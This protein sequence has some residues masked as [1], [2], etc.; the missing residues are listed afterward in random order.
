M[1]SNSPSLGRSILVVVMVSLGAAML[2]TGTH[3][4]SKD[5]I[6]FNERQRLLENLNSVLGDRLR[7]EDFT[8]TQLRVSNAELLGTQEPVD[9][10]VMLANGEPR[11][12]VIAA[13][14]PGGYNAPIRMLV[15]IL[16]DGTLSGVRIVD[17]RETPGLGDLIEAEKSDWIH[18]FESARLGRP[19]LPLWAVDKDGG[20]FDSLTG[21]TVTPRAI[22]EGVR[23]TLLY[24]HDHSEQIVLDARQSDA[25]G[26]DNE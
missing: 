13:I 7:A 12:I 9:V 23:N 1:V 11:A 10:F 14:A 5:R 2:V 25:D 4:F 3:E 21:A 17:H 20:T 26:T 19:E 16:P 18:Q 6:D 15:G 8:T 24:F 22:V